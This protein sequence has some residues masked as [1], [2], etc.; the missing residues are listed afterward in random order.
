MGSVRGCCH[1]KL[2]TVLLNGAE[3]LFPWT[4][5]NRKKFEQLELAQALFQQKCISETKRSEMCDD[6]VE[7]LYLLNMVEPVENFP[8]NTFG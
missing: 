1:S 7:V 2:R 5:D 3:A 4:K 8:Y 6:E